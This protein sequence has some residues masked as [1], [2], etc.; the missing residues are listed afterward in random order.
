MKKF[1]YVAANID[2]AVTFIKVNTN[3]KQVS[4]VVFVNGDERIV[5]ISKFINIRGRKCDGI[6]ID[7]SFR[8]LPDNEYTNFQERFNHLDLTPIE[9]ER[10]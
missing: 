3:W 8:N 1:F 9:I 6:Y 5:V 10:R 4:N 7:Y 2:H